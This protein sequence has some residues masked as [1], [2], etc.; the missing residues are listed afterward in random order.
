M[1]NLK[2]FFPLFL[3][4]TFIT[5]IHVFGQISSDEV[6]RLVENALKKF[7]VAGAAVG[8]V[9]D[10]KVIL[11]RGYGMKSLKNNQKADENTLFGIGSNSKAFT[12]AALAILV[13]EGKLSWQDR[14]IDYIPEFRMYN[15]YVTENFIIEDLLTHRSGLGLGVGDLMIFPD[16]SDFTIH[17]I[18]SSFQYF[19]PQSPF[20]T[21]FDYDNLLYLVAG[22]IIKKVSGLTWEEFVTQH[23]FKPLG[24][25]NTQPTYSWTKGMKNVAVPYSDVNGTLKEIP[26]FGDMVNGAAGGILSSANDMCKWMLVQLNKGQYGDSLEN[27]LFT[28]I[29]REKM[30]TIHTPMR[31]NKN[32]RYHSH[33]AGYGLGWMLKDVKGNLVVSH[34]GGMPGMLSKVTL[35]PDLNFGL[36]V[37]TNTSEGGSFVF[38][39][40]SRTIVDSYLGLDKIDWTEKIG[41]YAEQYKQKGDSVTTQVWETINANN[42]NV[43]VENYMGI[44]EDKWFGKTEIFLKDGQ[45]WFKSLRSPKLNGAM[46]YY[47]ANTFAVKWEYK[48]MNAD[49][50][51]IFCLDE[52]GKAQSIKMKGISP[53]IDFSFDFQDLDLKR[54][55]RDQ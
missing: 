13:E 48:D 49:A 34:T 20:R 26:P 23:I 38:E 41:E 50:F 37:L 8:I 55:A 30:W 32:P 2:T 44:Y 14:V 22:E 1:N 40:V 51:A 15:S 53:N 39:T 46:Y 17:D 25:N 29:A 3:L 27:T 47:K 21:K 9:K 4:F 6:D 12:T 42:E 24:M 45:L 16:S 31:V 10:G 5:S 54:V 11:A 19:Q 18:A 43:N 7:N 33:F 52:E 35:I 28:D 36:V